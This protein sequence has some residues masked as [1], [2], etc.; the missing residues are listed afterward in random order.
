MTV[1]DALGQVDSDSVA[2]TV[3]PPVVADAGAD[4]VIRAGDS[5]VLDGSAG[6]GLGPYSYDWLPTAGLDNPNIAGPTASPAATTTYTLTVTDDLGQVDT[7]QVTVTVAGPVIAEAGADAVIVVGSSTTLQG[8]ASGGYPPFSY[9]WSPTSGLDNPNIAGPTASPTT[10]TLYTLT[11]TDGLAQVDTDTV[12][13]TVVD[14]LA[15]DAGP[16]K[17]IAQGGS[18]TLEGS[19]T[20]GLPPYSHQWSPTG[21][22]DDPSVLQPTASPTTTTIYTLTVTDDE[23][24]TDTDTV[25]VTVVPPVVASAGADKMIRPG[26]SVVLDGSVTDGLGP[27]DYLWV[28]ATGLD[29]PTVPQPTASPTGTTV[30]IL[31]VTD[32]LGQTDQDTTTVTVTNVADF[33]YD[34]QVFMQ[35]YYILVDEW[36]GSNA[37]CDLDSNGMVFLGDYFIF[38]DNWGWQLP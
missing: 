35:D 30:Y 16:D 32:G 8:S 2:V 20:G 15:A 5:T 31:T 37:L 1:T 22:L 10:T 11:V 14:P 21:D 24:S 17:P 36:G 6:G 3:V 26:E 19:A 23:G 9:Q 29:D 18:T 4:K 13:V 12:T 28:P 27:Y 34:G 33:D 25:T 38:L 7:D